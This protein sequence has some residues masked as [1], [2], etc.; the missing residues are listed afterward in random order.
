MNFLEQDFAVFLW[1]LLEKNITKRGTNNLF[2]FFFFMSC[3]F[4]KYYDK[5]QF[6]PRKVHPYNYIAKVCLLY[7]VKRIPT[8]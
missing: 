5:R 4:E 7:H 1:F 8:I 6:D 3:T 2:F